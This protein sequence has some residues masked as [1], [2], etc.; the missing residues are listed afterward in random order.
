MPE[1]QPMTHKEAWKLA[2]KLRKQKYVVE[3]YKDSNNK[4]YVVHITDRI[5]PSPRKPVTTEIDKI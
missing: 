4:Q 2:E 5:V 3:I 1:H